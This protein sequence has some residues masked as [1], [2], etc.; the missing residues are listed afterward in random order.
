MAKE[1]KNSLSGS[2]KKL[3]EISSWFDEQEE[4]DLEKGLEKVKEGAK[5]IKESRAQL[6]NVENEFEEIKAEMEE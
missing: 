6:K 3:E 4:I 2:L 5:L 1:V